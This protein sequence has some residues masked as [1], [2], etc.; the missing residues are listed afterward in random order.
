MNNH[1]LK[2]NVCNFID[3]RLQESYLKIVK[4]MEYKTLENEYKSK[5]DEINRELPKKKKL[6]DEYKASEY[7][8]YN[9]QL[10]QAYKT[11]FVD[12]LKIMIER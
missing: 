11:G 9:M 8:L 1:S 12:S 2:Q 10:Q 4:N 6:I 5:F 7:D 3:E